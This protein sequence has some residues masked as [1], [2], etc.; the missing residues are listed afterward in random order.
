M[1]TIQY[2]IYLSSF[3]LQFESGEASTDL[4]TPRQPWLNH[5]LFGP[6]ELR[7]VLLSADVGMVEVNDKN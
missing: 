7:L 4:L 6:V 5:V 1:T 3:S 2:N